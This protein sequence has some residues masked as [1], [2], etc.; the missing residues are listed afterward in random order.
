MGNIETTT[1]RVLLVLKIIIERQ[2]PEV[3][4]KKKTVFKNFAKLE[5]LFNKVAG[6]QPAGLLKKGS[7]TGAFCAYCKC[8]KNI[9][10]EKHLRTAVSAIRRCFSKKM[11]LIYLF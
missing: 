4:Y 3:F 2:P 11:F 1:I 9:Y 8:F 10:F 6:L 5:C 7:N